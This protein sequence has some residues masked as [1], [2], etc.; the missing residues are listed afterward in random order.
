MRVRD[1]DLA[2][3][4]NNFGQSEERNTEARQRLRRQVR[5][6]WLRYTSS[7]DESV[8]QAAYLE[9]GRLA[10]ELERLDCE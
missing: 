5:A 6:A 8:V 1:I 4:R 9:W 2:I 10:D 7:M 3:N